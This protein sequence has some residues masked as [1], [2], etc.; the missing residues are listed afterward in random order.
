MCGLRITFV[1]F[2][3]GLKYLGL[4]TTVLGWI[5][6]VTLVVA[7]AAWAGLSRLSGGTRSRSVQ[8]A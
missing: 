2:I 4:S 3:S 7:I 8:T 5:A 6:A 1:I